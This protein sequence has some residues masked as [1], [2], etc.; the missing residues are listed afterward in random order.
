MTEKWIRVIYQG[1]TY[2]FTARDQLVD[3]H[4]LVILRQLEVFPQLLIL[5]TG[6]PRVEGQGDSSFTSCS[7]FAALFA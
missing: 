4:S 1:H 2:L 6:Q 7:A 5:R 3:E